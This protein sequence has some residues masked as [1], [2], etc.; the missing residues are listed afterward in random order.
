MEDFESIADKQPHNSV[1][2]PKKSNEDGDS[3]QFKRG[4]VYLSYI[5]EGMTVKNIRQIFSKFGVVERIFLEKENGL[6]KG[7]TNKSRDRRIKYTEGWVEFKKKSVA[8]MVASCLNGAQVG[9]KRR[10][11][12]YDALWSIKYLKRFV[13][14]FDKLLLTFVFLDSNGVIWPSK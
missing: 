2:D 14:C 4:V 13:H 12:F 3:K 6:K 1:L 9:G 10:T 7:R 5:P 8:K 11:K